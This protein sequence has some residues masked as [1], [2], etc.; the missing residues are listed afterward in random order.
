M[1]SKTQRACDIFLKNPALSIREMQDIIGCSDRTVKS[2]R[3]KAKQ[4]MQKQADKTITEKFTDTVSGNERS[5]VTTSSDIRT[6]EELIEFA[7]IDLDK[8]EIVKHT[9]NS[10][11]S[12][13]NENFQVKVWLKKYIEEFSIKEYIA[14]FKEAAQQHVPQVYEPIHINSENKNIA[15]EIGV[16][17]L[18]FGS[19]CWGEETGENYDIKIA[20]KVYL[21]AIKYFA[22]IAKS[23]NPK[24]IL[25]PIGSD[26]FNV[27]NIQNATFNN[28]VQDEDSRYIKTYILARK[29]IVKAIDILINVCPVV[30]VPIIPG[31]HDTT[32]TLMLSDSL[33]SWYRDCENVIIEN[34]PMPRKYWKWGKCLLMLTHG[35][36]EVKGT[37]PMIFANEAAEHWGSTI[38]RHIHKGHLHHRASKSYDY[39]TEN[40]GIR[41]H[42]LPSLAATDAWHKSKGY[43]GLRSASLFVWDKNKGNIAEFNYFLPQ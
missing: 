6:L 1:K 34:S 2:G 29:M 8:W 37:L 19:L 14:E 7:N 12:G 30:R 31:N 23:F 38:Y 43:S 42:I 33:E 11:G 10:W 22:A 4:I 27:D 35:A 16:H 36:S 28:T 5:F 39:G 40:Q 20:E 21:D 24:E 25:F 41:E 3:K 26:L 13:R 17:D 18:H 15:I 9:I 32:R